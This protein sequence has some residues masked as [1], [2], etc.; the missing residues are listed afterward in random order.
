MSDFGIYTTVIKQLEAHPNADRL[1]IAKVF[2]T[3]VCVPKG[4][5]NQG[6]VVIYFPPDIMIPEH[7][8]AKLGVQNYLRSGIYKETRC[9]CRVAA[10]RLRGCPSFGFIEKCL[11][12]ELG[13][14]MT[15]AYGGRKYQP[16]CR[17][18][19][20]DA[21]HDVVGFEKYTSIE[22]YWK[23]PDVFSDLDSVMITEKVHGTNFRAGKVDGVIHV[24]SH[25]IR[26]KFER[27]GIYGLPLQDEDFVKVLD[28]A[29]EDIVI[30]GEIYGEGV[31]DMDYGTGR[32][33]YAIFDIVTDGN[34]WAPE[35]TLAF[36]KANNLP[37]VP[38]LYTGRYHVGLVEEY[39]SGNT[40]Y[41]P[42]KNFE[43]REGIVIKP[44]EPFWHNTI[45]RAV[46]KSVSADYYARKEDEVLFDTGE[47]YDNPDQE[48]DTDSQD[49]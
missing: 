32:P 9:K 12:R 21:D 27:P 40:E 49:A 3:Q 23:Y 30:Y 18:S 14:D 8:S 33:T 15:A 24:G 48:T 17:L 11:G 6:E 36:C 42:S 16:P 1:E 44:L 25:N 7:V 10:V 34:Y 35:D 20:G 19:L 45:G 31:Q 39:T 13:V 41:L 47:K 2:G 26:R 46:L 28:A 4:R 43:G 29:Q 38:V 5:F 22:H 37:H